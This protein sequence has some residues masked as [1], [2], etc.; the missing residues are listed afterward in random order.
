LR[1]CSENWSECSSAAADSASR[2][3]VP[4]DGGAPE[5]GW[6]G[7]LELGVRLGSL[8][9]PPLCSAM[10]GPMRSIV[11]NTSCL[12]GGLRRKC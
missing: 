6:P 10:S 2:K 11:A 3:D 7:G 5:V 4:L 1:A 8:T 9:R 12:L